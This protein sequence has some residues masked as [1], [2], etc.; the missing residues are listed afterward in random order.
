MR[1]GGKAWGALTL[2]P[3]SSPQGPCQVGGRK[4]NLQ[5]RKKTLSKCDPESTQG[6]RARCWQDRQ[7]AGL[8]QGMVPFCK[9]FPA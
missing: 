5:R 7:S 4:P 9:G 1:L 2:L 8:S 6:H 3:S